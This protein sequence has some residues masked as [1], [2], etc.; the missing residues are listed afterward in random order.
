MILPRTSIWLPHVYAAALVF[1]GAVLLVVLW[2]VV[3]GMFAGGANAAPD[4]IFFTVVMMV[5]VALAGLPS[6]VALLSWHL[7]RRK[8]ASASPPH[9]AL[10]AGLAALLLIVIAAEV[11]S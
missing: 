9:M 7:C 5:P 6:G 4:T 2:L 8:G 11:L 1:H 3:T 10:T